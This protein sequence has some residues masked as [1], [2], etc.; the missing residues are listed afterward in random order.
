MLLTDVFALPYFHNSLFLSLRRWDFNAIPPREE[1]LSSR[2]LQH[3]AYTFLALAALI[4]DLVTPPLDF[5]VIHSN[6]E[7]HDNSGYGDTCRERCGK[8][9]V[10]LRDN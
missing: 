6:T 3:R 10:I 4:W 9:E 7:E 2:E 8:Y 5:N 1:T